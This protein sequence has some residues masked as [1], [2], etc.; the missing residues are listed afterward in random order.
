MED[1]AVV[2][3]VDHKTGSS[4]ILAYLLE[5]SGFKMVVTGNSSEAVEF[6]R[7]RLFDL[8][9]MKYDLPLLNGVALAKQMK[10]LQSNLPVIMISGRSTLPP[11]QLLEVDAHFGS[12][13]SLDDLV[14]T[15]R[16]LTQMKAPSSGH[17][18]LGAS[19]ADST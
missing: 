1:S 8:A 15:M 10:S 7:R 12:G 3:Y 9:L 17:R 19:W 18:Q 5:E 13:T 4:R 16:M 2:L 6:C 14:H 11:D